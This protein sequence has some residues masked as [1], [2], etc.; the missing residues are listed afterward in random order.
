MPD[1]AYNWSWVLTENNE[2]L[3]LSCYI[4]PSSSISHNT[5][6][7]VVVIR[8]NCTNS[9]ENSLAS[10]RKL[11]FLHTRST[12]SLLRIY[13]SS[14]HPRPQPSGIIS[15]ATAVTSPPNMLRS[16]CAFTGSPF[17]A[18]QLATEEE[19][20]KA[21]LS[22]LCK[23]YE[24][25]PLSTWLLN[26][27]IPLITNKSLATSQ[28][29]ASFKKAVVCPLL[30]MRHLFA[31]VIKNYHPFSNPS[32]LSKL[33]ERIASTRIDTH[34]VANNLHNSYQSVYTKHH[35]IETALFRVQMVIMEALDI[36]HSV[37][38]IM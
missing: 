27:L 21:L 4:P 31:Q 5:K 29:P 3:Y 30:V 38:L 15:P 26:Q 9:Q 35:L 10:L 34:L 16:M 24:L 19:V 6:T 13:P 25:D 32:F 1:K 37:A 23:S 14:S 22:A 8:S 36:G 18:F 7:S 17:S 33:W 2:G 11:Y 12:Q 28:V 20:Q